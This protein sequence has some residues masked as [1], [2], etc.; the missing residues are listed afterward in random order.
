M[1]RRSQRVWLCRGG[2]PTRD[3][4]M[5]PICSSLW[6]RKRHDRMVVAIGGPKSLAVVGDATRFKRKR[7]QRLHRRRGSIDAEPL[8]LTLHPVFVDGRQI[9]RTVN[10]RHTDRTPFE[11]Y[12]AHRRTVL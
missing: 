9:E 8:E 1:Q 3:L 2:V 10:D 6:E 11:L 5:H 4:T 12:F 7:L